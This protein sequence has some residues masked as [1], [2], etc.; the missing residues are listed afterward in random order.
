MRNEFNTEKLMAQVDEPGNVFLLAHLNDEFSGYAR[1]LESESPPEL[2]GIEAIELSRIYVE[3]KITAQGIGTAL[4]QRSVDTA[5]GKNKKT[6][7]LGVW[8]HNL[9]AI[10]FYERFGFEIFGGHV[11]ML[12]DDEQTDLLM[13]KSL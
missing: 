11:F 3:T 5:R 10:S 8:E 2:C 12:G 13:K 6:I 4:L 1:L 7:W 9:R